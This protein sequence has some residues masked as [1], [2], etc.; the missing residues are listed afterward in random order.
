M[1]PVLTVIALMLGAAS[2]TASSPDVVSSSGV[3]V[4]ESGQGESARPEVRRASSTQGLPFA[5]DDGALILYGAMM[6]T[7]MCLGVGVYGITLLLG[8]D[9]SKQAFAG[10][11]QI[12][13]DNRTAQLIGGGLLAAGGFAGFA[14]GA[15][16]IWLLL[17]E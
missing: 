13:V 15:V 12:D 14:G 9:I 3:L 16:G 1:K 6:F 7:G 17:E 8:V 2:A 10:L 11:T 4:L 5:D